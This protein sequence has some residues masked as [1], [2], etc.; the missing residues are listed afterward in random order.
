MYGSDRMGFEP[1]V[2]TVSLGKLK[3]L[4]WD[5]ETLKWSNHVLVLV[6]VLHC[7]VPV[8][9]LKYL[10]YEKEKYSE[11]RIRISEWAY[12]DQDEDV[13]ITYSYSCCWSCW[14]PRILWSRICRFLDRRERPCR[15]W[16]TGC[17]SQISRDHWKRNSTCNHEKTCSNS[18]R[19]IQHIQTPLV[20]FHHFPAVQTCCLV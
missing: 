20:C 13:N 4:K 14:R 8:S 5:N 6:L 10:A 7:K 1:S 15:R 2:S 17:R 18:P 9:S 3:M 16:C 12:L 19:T 11:Y